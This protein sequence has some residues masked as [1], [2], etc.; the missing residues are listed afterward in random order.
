M[1]HGKVRLLSVFRQ[2]FLLSLLVQEYKGSDFAL[3]TDLVY[4]SAVGSDPSAHH[5]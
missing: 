4:I 1:L 5:K 3:L 2:N